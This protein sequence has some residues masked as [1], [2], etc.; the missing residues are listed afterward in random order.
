MMNYQLLKKYYKWWNRKKSYKFSIESINFINSQKINRLDN[1]NDGTCLSKA[2]LEID[3]IIFE[4]LSKLDSTM[5]LLVKKE[6]LIINYL[7][8]LNT[9]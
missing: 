1:K 9:G 4:T 8:A 5:L 7:W 2:D 6:V 3:K